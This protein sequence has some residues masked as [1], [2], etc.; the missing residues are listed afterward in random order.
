[1]DE[2]AGLPTIERPVNEQAWC[3]AFSAAHAPRIFAAEEAADWLGGDVDVD[4][5]EAQMLAG[6]CL[7]MKL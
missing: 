5:H 7:S 6:T 1:M 4:D 3:A 2:L